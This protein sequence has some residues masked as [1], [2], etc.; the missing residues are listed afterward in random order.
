VT[1]HTGKQLARVCDYAKKANSINT[2]L[3]TPRQ[4]NGPGFDLGAGKA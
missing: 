4:R 3:I 1:G 2:I